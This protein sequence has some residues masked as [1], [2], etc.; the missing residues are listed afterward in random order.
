[1]AHLVV[2]FRRFI[3]LGS[4]G[5]LK[6]QV[7]EDFGEKFALFEKRP[8]TEKF[9][10]FC[11]ERIH[12]DTDP[13]LMCKFRE[14]RPTGNRWN[15]VLFTSQKNKL[16]LALSLLL[17]RRSHPKSAKASGR[18]CSQSAQISRKSVHFR[19]SYSRTCEHRQNAS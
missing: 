13:C 16:C 19:Q 1:M 2:S 17:L 11:S 10:K 8:L 7:I 6:S 14:I 18:Q 9:S 4:Y 3:S 12:R 15:L 5:G